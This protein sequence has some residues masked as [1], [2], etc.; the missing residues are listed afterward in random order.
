MKPANGSVYIN[1]EK[2]PLP[3]QVIKNIETVIGMQV[4]QNRDTAVHLRLLR[5]IATLFGTAPF[6]YAE[7]LFFAVWFGCSQATTEPTLP[8]NIPKYDI[9]EYLLDTVALLITTG[10]LI[11]QTRQ[12]KLAEQRSHLMLQINLLT[13]QK[14]AKLIELI[15][16]L[17]EDLPDL[18][19]R[20]DWEADLMKQATNPQDVLDILQENLEQS[21]HPNAQVKSS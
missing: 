5:K 17:R 19:N 21:E 18:E 10:V 7:L 9:Y 4:Q 1:G 14:T 13:E 20:R 16:E 2:Y 11:Y 6:L 3:D 12:E 15:E 8:L